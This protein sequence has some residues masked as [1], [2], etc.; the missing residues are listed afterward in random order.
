MCC[1]EMLC[2]AAKGLRCDDELMSDA[3]QDIGVSVMLLPCVLVGSRR[4]SSCCRR[5]VQHWRMVDDL[6]AGR[7]MSNRGRKLGI[8]GMCTFGCA[9][10][11]CAAASWHACMGCGQQ[12]VLNFAM[13]QVQVAGCH[14][15]GTLQAGCCSACACALP[16]SFSYQSGRAH[17]VFVGVAAIVEMRRTLLCAYAV[18]PVLHASC[19]A[20]VPSSSFPLV[21]ANVCLGRLFA[22][23]V[24]PASNGQSFADTLHCV[25]FVL[26]AGC[27]AQVSPIS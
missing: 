11:R 3:L 8:E 25:Y 14:A 5:S 2:A 12:L 18:M 20:R 21:R 16:W 9:L 27:P 22:Q 26:S 7:L 4:D 24:V 23:F 1:L 13:L 19:A 6:L 17:M 15:A 10:L